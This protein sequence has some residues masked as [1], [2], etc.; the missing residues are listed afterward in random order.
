MK[1]ILFIV[2]LLLGCLNVKAQSKYI[3]RVKKKESDSTGRGF[4]EKSVID[5]IAAL[6]DTDAYVQSFK[7]FFSEIKTKDKVSKHGFT[8]NYDFTIEDLS[9]VDLDKKVSKKVLDSLEKL[10]RR[11]MYN[12]TH[13]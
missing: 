10:I 1:K 8:M 9:G 7:K 13:Q 3:L 12:N 4:I 2:F 6:N 5:T 11:S